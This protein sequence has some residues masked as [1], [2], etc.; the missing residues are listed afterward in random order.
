[1]CALLA[2]HWP[3]PREKRELASTRSPTN[4]GEYTYFTLGRNGTAED[5]F[6]SWQSE[7]ESM[8]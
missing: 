3:R 7:K 8:A 6:K 4:E 5:L 2:K 1:M